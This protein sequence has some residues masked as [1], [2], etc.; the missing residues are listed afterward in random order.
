MAS[1]KSRVRLDLVPGLLERLKTYLKKT[2]PR[3]NIRLHAPK[4]I[5]WWVAVV[6]GAL[7]VLG[8]FVSIPVVSGLSFWLITAGLVILILA[9]L[10]KNPI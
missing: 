4:Q 1:S 9:T 6:V 5:T 10:F 3:R 7:G 8:Q 2:I